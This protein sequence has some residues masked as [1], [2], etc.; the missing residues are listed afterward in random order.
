[1]KIQQLRIYVK[2]I[3]KALD[4]LTSKIN[5]KIPSNYYQSELMRLREAIDK[6]NI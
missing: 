2:E 1:M 3:Q 5:D 6:I 4:D